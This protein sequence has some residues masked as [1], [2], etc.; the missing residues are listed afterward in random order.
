MLYLKSQP[1]F[2]TLKNN[3]GFPPLLH[4][5]STRVIHLF[6][7]IS[8]LVPL[9]PPLLPLTHSCK[10]S[11]PYTALC[12]LPAPSAPMHFVLAKNLCVFTNKRGFFVTAFLSAFPMPCMTMQLQNRS[13]VE[14]A[15][16]PVKKKKTASHLEVVVS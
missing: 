11:N 14:R 10:S 3:W 13:L 4:S 1:P 5:M 12:C 8:R 15:G 9:M 2:F 6:F 16:E 7:N